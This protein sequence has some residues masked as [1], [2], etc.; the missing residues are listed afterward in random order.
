[1][2][3]LVTFYYNPEH[4]RSVR[5]SDAALGIKMA[6]RGSLEVI[7][8][9]DAHL[10]LLADLGAVFNPVTFGYPL[11]GSGVEFSKTSID[12]KVSTTCAFW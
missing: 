5:W 11:T 12:L 7:S 8:K 10:P 9:K 2:F 3:Y 1:V 4:E 6:R